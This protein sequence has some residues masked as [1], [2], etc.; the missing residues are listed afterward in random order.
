MDITDH[1]DWSLD[2]HD[3]ALL[4]QQLFRFGAYCFNDGV[5]E[6]L[7]A[8]QTRDAFVKINTG[9]TYS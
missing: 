4:H 5:R 2:V 7:L 1:C 6:E 9:C 3:I 8:V